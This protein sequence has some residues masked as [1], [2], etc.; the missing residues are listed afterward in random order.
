MKNLNTP[1]NKELA[2]ILLDRLHS[3]HMKALGSIGDEA[4]DNMLEGFKTIVEESVTEKGL[5][6]RLDNFV[7]FVVGHESYKNLDEDGRYKLKIVEYMGEI[8]EAHFSDVFDVEE[9]I[10]PILNVF[11]NI[12]IDSGLTD[13]E[14]VDKIV[15]Y[16]SEKSESLN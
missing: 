15:N 6:K 7:E 11:K 4:M 2:E 12:T 14:L 10:S 3:V 1:T 16:L 5:I 9:E 8:I 13:E